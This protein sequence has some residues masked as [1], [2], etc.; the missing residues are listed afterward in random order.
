MFG[1]AS[2]NKEIRERAAARLLETIFTWVAQVDLVQRPDHEQVAICCVEYGV[3]AFKP[4]HS[5]FGCGRPGKYELSDERHDPS[6]AARPG[7]APFSLALISA[8]V[9]NSSLSTVKSL[10]VVAFIGTLWVLK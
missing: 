5:S 7:E 10:V 9:R 3:S 8:S 4:R 2:G 1:Q 6:L